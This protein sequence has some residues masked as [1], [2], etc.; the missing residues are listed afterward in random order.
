MTLLPDELLGE[1]FASIHGDTPFP[2]YN[3]DQAAKLNTGRQEKP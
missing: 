2:N 1:L 3:W